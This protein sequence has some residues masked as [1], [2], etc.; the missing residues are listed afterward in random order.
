MRPA[1]R[2]CPATQAGRSPAPVQ[3]AE[4]GADGSE[5]AM[6][7]A[8]YAAIQD[9]L[10]NGY[11]AEDGARRPVRSVKHALFLAQGGTIQLPT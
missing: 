9:L 1:V 5:Q 4:T 10:T 6:S 7:A 2:L 11:Q 3:H 8:R